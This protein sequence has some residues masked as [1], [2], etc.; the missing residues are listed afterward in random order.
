MNSTERTI[1]DEAK[2]VSLKIIEC[3]RDAMQGLKQF[4][5]TEKKIEYIN[6]LLKVGFHTIDFG[7]FVSPKAIPQLADTADVVRGLD[8]KGTS[9]ELLVIIGNLKGAEKALE[10]DQIKYIGFPFSTSP[11][12]LKLNINTT[13]DEALRNIDVIHNL[14]A[15]SGKELVLYLSMAFGNPYGD[16]C[17]VGAIT[18][19]IDILKKIGIKSV[20]LADT[21]GVGGPE[22]VDDIFRRVI[23]K[24]TDMEIGF[25]L[26]TTKAHWYEKVNNSYAA[27]CRRFDSVILGLGGCPMSSKDLVGNL[28][29]EDLL[30]FFAE[31]NIKTDI[32]FEAFR[33]SWEIANKLFNNIH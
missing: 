26:H 18:D 12:F 32:N 8:L 30:Q 33:N 28:S 24:Y 19:A 14:C 10:F 3:P 13:L 2:S 31:K 17:C 29:T 4:I 6:S 20:N 25:H 11:T 16:N 15:K 7:S 1:N 22:I 21:L 23:P 27:G 9:T 5:P